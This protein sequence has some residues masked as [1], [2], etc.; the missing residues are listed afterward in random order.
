MSGKIMFGEGTAAIG[1]L[2]PRAAY[3][4]TSG[5]VGQSGPNNPLLSGDG[6]A[7]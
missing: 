7:S 6:G 2:A 5:Y 1:I 3:S 4:F